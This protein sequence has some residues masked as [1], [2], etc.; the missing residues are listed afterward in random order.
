MM[1][2][3]RIASV[4]LVALA[5]LLT[6]GCCRQ[7]T[8]DD[9]VNP[10]TK[11]GGNLQLT[12]NVQALRTMGNEWE[13]NDAIGVFPYTGDQL[14]ADALIENS[15]KKGNRKYVTT[16]TS[17]AFSSAVEGV[18]LESGVTANLIAYYPYSASVGD[19]LEV[20]FSTANQSDL[21]AI[22]L[23]YSNNAKGL[24]QT[25]NQAALIFDHML[26][27]VT[28]QVTA[29]N[30]DLT[31]KQL[32][33]SEVVVDGKMSLTD[34]AITNGN[35]KKAFSSAL[36]KE[37]STYNV[38][39]ILPAQDLTQVTV[40]IPGVTKAPKAI[41]L[42]AAKGK[43]HIV[44]ITIDAQGQ[45]HISSAVINDWEAGEGPDA[46]IV[47]DP[48]DE[49]GTGGDQPG[50]GDNPGGGDEPAPAPTTKL[51]F[52]GADFEDF[53]AFKAGLNQYG[54]QDYATQST[55]GRNGT[56]A[57]HINGT[58]KR[59]D[60]I[61]TI[62]AS[63]KTPTSISKIHMWIKGTSE[64]SLSFNL[65]ME[66]GKNYNVF[67]LDAVGEKG[68]LVGPADQ[69]IVLKPTELNAPDA[70]RSPGNG[71]NSYTEGGIDTKGQWVEVTLDCT[72]L[73]LPNNTGSFFALKVGEKKVWNLLIDDITFE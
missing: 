9:L 6:V 57:L 60:Y 71:K 5:A 29:A 45:L 17:G 7:K 24:T 58:P 25:N 22:D 59:N 4:L 69:P 26:S 65:Y 48:N 63:D 11:R 8:Q 23:L 73:T 15:G 64:K 27:M 55:E 41:G 49:P 54:L 36:V 32:A 50:T 28:F 44:P 30:V 42:T 33:L 51:L 39:L 67:N 47:L 12:A 66:N 61:F 19:A 16:G 21:G 72:G 14:K 38:T 35:T 18:W 43:K 56:K 31:G 70:R 1:K 34:G 3:V 62:L 10:L 68:H 40:N 13:A 20:P 52:P 37:G 53:D 46:P 2:N